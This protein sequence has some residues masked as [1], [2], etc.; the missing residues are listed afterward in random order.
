VG[1]GRLPHEISTVVI[2]I[3]EE[4]EWLPRLGSNE[5]FYLMDSVS[6]RGMKVLKIAGEK[7]VAQCVNVQ[8]TAGTWERIKWQV[9]CLFKNASHFH[10]SACVHVL[11]I[12][13]YPCMGARGHMTTCVEVQ[14]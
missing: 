2:G 11:A 12:C 5:E 6:L 14:G 4:V 7:L 13:G 10:E 1:T 9:S 3:K 8:S